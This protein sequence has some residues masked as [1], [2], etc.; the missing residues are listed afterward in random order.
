[1]VNQLSLC[2]VYS[3]N[4]NMDISKNDFSLGMG[5]TV[6]IFWVAVWIAL[7]SCVLFCW[8]MG[9]CCELVD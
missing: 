3:G 2:L 7:C 6:R 4:Y 8:R 5:G 1:M 9:I